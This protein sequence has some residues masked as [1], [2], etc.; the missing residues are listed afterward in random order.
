M[1]AIQTGGPMAEMLAQTASSLITELQVQQRASALMSQGWMQAWVMGC[2]PIG[3]MA[4]LS[5]MDER[6]GPA[7]V[8]T[9]VGQ[10]LVGVLLAL[11]LFG[12]LW[13]RRIARKVAHG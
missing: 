8:E 13:L 1:V 6:F 7:L 9:T 2:L 12:I 5:Q 11:E 3:L 10:M 4:V